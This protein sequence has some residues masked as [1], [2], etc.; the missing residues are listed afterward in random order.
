MGCHFLLQGDVPDP[1]IEPGSL[2]LWADALPS[3]PPKPH[4]LPLKIMTL[5]EWNDQH[6]ITMLNGKGEHSSLK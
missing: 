4:C 5:L 3:E 6:L 1:G 2:A